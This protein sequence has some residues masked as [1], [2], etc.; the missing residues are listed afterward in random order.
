M[1]VQQ[2]TL[3]V[4]WKQWNCALNCQLELLVFADV[5]PRCTGM[6][7]T[8]VN[9]LRRSASVSMTEKPVAQPAPLCE[10]GE[11]YDAKRTSLLTDSGGLRRPRSDLAEGVR[12]R[13]PRRKCCY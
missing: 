12:T 2:G 9:S 6:T 11:I 8:G 7:P 10:H 5:L 4:K 1:L 13:S 3:G